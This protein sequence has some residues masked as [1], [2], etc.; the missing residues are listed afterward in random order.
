M[1]RKIAAAAIGAT[2]LAIA[3]GALGATN[4]GFTIPNPF[5][6]G[7]EVSPDQRHL[8]DPVIRDT[9]GVCWDI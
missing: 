5:S 4:S 6:W 3:V 8:S 1:N 9:D 2:G 7:S